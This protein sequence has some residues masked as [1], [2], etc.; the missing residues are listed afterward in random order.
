MF[1]C[2]Q[3]RRIELVPEPARQDSECGK[4]GDPREGAELE[5]EAE[6]ELGCNHP[7]DRQQAHRSDQDWRNQQHHRQRLLNQNG[8]SEERQKGWKAQEGGSEGR[9]VLLNAERIVDRGA[10]PPGG[11]HHLVVEQKQIKA[12]QLPKQSEGADGNNLIPASGGWGRLAERVHAEASPER[13]K[14]TPE[15]NQAEQVV[16]GVVNEG[17]AILKRDEKD[18]RGDAGH[19]G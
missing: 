14:H 3:S 9:P 11:P 13:E 5:A 1:N 2:L 16:A 4:A 17:I 6:S 10:V 19:P 18:P 8:M 15:K 7:Q 12:D